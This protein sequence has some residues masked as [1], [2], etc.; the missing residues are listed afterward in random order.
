MRTTITISIDFSNES[1]VLWWNLS[2]KKGYHPKINWMKQA[3]L[4]LDKHSFGWDMRIYQEIKN[5]RRNK[6]VINDIAT[7]IS[8]DWY[9]IN[10]LEENWNIIW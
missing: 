7:I 4:P 6:L 1:Q 10:F 8:I 3:N 2:S 5:Q 9:W